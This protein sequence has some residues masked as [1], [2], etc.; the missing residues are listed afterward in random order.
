M[1][2]MHASAA[3]AAPAV[4]VGVR[5]GFPDSFSLLNSNFSTYPDKNSSNAALL[6]R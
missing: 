6:M 5:S 3:R 4:V 2:S 1:V